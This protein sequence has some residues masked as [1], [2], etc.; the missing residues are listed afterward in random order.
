MRAP[1]PSTARTKRAARVAT[2]DRRPRKFSATRSPPSS[3]PAIKLVRAIDGRGAES[4]RAY[5]YAYVNSQF[6]SGMKSPLDAAILG[7]HHST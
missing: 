7:G 3:E 5:A 1:V 6:E 4:T 2:P